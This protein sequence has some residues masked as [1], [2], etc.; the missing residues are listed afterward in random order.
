MLQADW[1]WKWIKPAKVHRQ[2]ELR[3]ARKDEGDGEK[4]CGI[5]TGL[6]LDGDMNKPGK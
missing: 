6:F 5:L 2:Q 3:T 1:E 4:H